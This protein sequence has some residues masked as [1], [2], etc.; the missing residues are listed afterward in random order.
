MPTSL[1]APWVRGLPCLLVAL[2]CAGCGK[3]DSPD[4][5]G[6][7]KAGAGGGGAAS[8]GA[9]SGGK[10]PGSGGTKTNLPPVAVVPGAPNCGLSD[11]VAFCEQFDAAAAPGKQGRAGELDNTLWSGSREQPQLPTRNGLSIG[12]GGAKLAACR[13]GLPES[14]YPNQ[15][16]LI[17]DPTEAIPSNHLMVLTAAQNYGQN[18][19]RVRQPFDFAGRNAKLVFDAEGYLINNLLG[20]ISVEVTEDPMPAPSFSVGGPMTSND[21]GGEIPKNGI[22]LQ[23]QDSCGGTPEAPLVGLRMLVVYQDY[24]ATVVNPDS[25]VCLKARQAHLNHFELT[26]SDSKVEVYGTDYSEGGGKFGETKLMFSADVQLPFTRG[27]LSVT[28]HNHATLK[29][30]D[31]HSIDAWTARW[32]NVG[33]D[34]PKVTNTREY[35]IPDLLELGQDSV[36]LG[37][38]LMNIGYRVAAAKDGP[39]DK[40]TFKNVDPAG[41][42]KAQ[43]SLSCWYVEGDMIKNYALSYRLNGGAFHDRPLSAAEIE[44]RSGH[45]SQGQLAQVMEVPVSELVAGDNTLEIVASNEVPQGYPPIVSNID[46]VLS[47]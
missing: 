39:S 32:D 1:N 4:S 11:A 33:F 9:A 40:F 44:I 42:T 24:V 37:P 43:L 15:D 27:Y 47:E 35:E 5:D 7:G 13:D 28:T 21:E 34:G 8:A 26:V 29:Y 25:H 38:M 3:N 31:E 12:I 22:E 16:S 46:L 20:W 23:F 19:Y 41:A 30:S 2:L 14:V 6:P 18:S 17:C 45:A 10:P 36:D